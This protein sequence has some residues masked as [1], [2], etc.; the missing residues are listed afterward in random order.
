MNG[1]IDLVDR[2]SGHIRVLAGE[3]GER[4]VWHPQA[5]RAAAEY[6]R[7][8][9]CA[10]G[11]RV[12]EQSYQ[13]YGLHCV[14]LEAGSPHSLRAPTILIGAHYD[15][16]R[17][18]PGANDNASGVATLLELSRLL[19][20]TSDTHNLRFVGFVNEEAPFFATARQGSELYARKAREHGTK[21]ELMIA[22]ETMGCYSDEPD[23]QRYPPLLR[24][25]YPDRA[26]F[27]AMVSN[28]RC[29]GHLR[30]IVQAFRMSS[31]FP[32]RQLVGPAA[33]P[34]LSWSDHNAFWR[35]GYPAIMVTDTAFYRY[36]YYHTA[37][38]TPERVCSRELAQVTLGLA[39][40]IKR[41][42]GATCGWRITKK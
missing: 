32:V 20:E 26:N 22:L 15:S 6:L 38:D 23:S 16:V 9:W 19:R 5:L 8:Q 27:L 34:G 42:A 30:R 2:L 1:D 35:Q 3:I 37:L 40:A 33:I 28:F 17:G 21:I 29:C 36:P 25:F 12:S 18:S 41:I 7:A 10:Q 24:F 11:Y 14:N 13:V 4:N 31:D 39:G